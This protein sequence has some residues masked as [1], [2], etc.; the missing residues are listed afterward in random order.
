MLVQLTLSSQGTQTTRVARG[1]QCL[2]VHATMCCLHIQKL[3]SLC[4]VG[5]WY[6]AVRTTVTSGHVKAQTQHVN[7]L[8]V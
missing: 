4:Q 2:A 5:I 7:L 1:M 3:L 6:C 8:P